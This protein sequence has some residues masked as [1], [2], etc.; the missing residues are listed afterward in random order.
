MDLNTLL[1]NDQLD[2]VRKNGM[3]LQ[4]INNQTPEMCLEAVK[5]DVNTLRYVQPHLQTQEMCVKAIQQNVL[6][7]KFI[8]NKNLKRIIDNFYSINFDDEVLEFIRMNP[9][10]E[11]SFNEKQKELYDDYCNRQLTK[12]CK[13]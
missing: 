11:N 2:A 9:S 13:D 8:T 4:Y 7:L 12:S 1:Y 6:T 3:N 10:V 5:Q